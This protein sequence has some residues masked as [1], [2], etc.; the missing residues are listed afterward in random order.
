MKEMGGMKL[1]FCEIT[2]LVSSLTLNPGLESV[3][4]NTPI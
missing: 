4:H 3:Y 2:L 1:N